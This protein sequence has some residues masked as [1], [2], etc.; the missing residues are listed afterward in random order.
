MRKIM[1]P[2][3][4][5]IAHSARIL[6]SMHTRFCLATGTLFVFDSGPRY[7]GALL[8]LAIPGSVVA[9]TAYLTL[10]GRLGPERA[11]YSTVLFPIVAL[12]IS[13]IFEG[14]HW[15]T[16]ALAGLV[17]VML[18]NMLVFRRRLVAKRD[19]LPGFAE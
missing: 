11:A 17:L 19:S 9:F 14:Y 1:Q 12:N 8:Y 15:S 10:V 3:D 16:T 5:Q 13:A 18:G 7:T 6:S 2:Q 4:R